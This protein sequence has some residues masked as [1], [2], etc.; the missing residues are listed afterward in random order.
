MQQNL[1]FHYSDGMDL[2]NALEGFVSVLPKFGVKLEI[3]RGGDGFEEVKLT[4][5]E[6]QNAKRY[7]WLRNVG[8]AYQMQEWLKAGLSLSQI[9]AEIDKAIAALNYDL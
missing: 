6:D 9:D 8:Q 3:L 2:Y 5:L 1:K 7:L 4:K